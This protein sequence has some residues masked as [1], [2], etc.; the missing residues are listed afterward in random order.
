MEEKNFQI[1][2]RFGK[3]DR[4]PELMRGACAALERLERD[5]KSVTHFL[6]KSRDK[7]KT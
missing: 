3:A 1:A 5:P 4:P 7:T 6:N 2:L